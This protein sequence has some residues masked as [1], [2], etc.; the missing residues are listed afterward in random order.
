MFGSGAPDAKG[1]KKI[2]RAMMWHTINLVLWL[3]MLGALLAPADQATA[4][5]IAIA[6]LA[7]AAF[8]EH[9]MIRGFLKHKAPDKGSPG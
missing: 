7:A 8:R 6:G 5:W 4:R 2:P 1:S 9:A 3:A